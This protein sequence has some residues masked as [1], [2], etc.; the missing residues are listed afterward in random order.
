MY[1]HYCHDL[2]F[3]RGPVMFTL[4]LLLAL[5]APASWSGTDSSTDYRLGPGDQIK[6]SVL[7]EDNLS[8]E[9][10]LSEQGTISYP[11]LG[12][13]DVG[14]K[15]T[16]EVEAII[17]NGL[18]GKYLIDPKVS[19][20][21]VEFRKFFVGGA[22]RGPG[23]FPFAPGMTMQ[24]AIAIAGGLTDEASDEILVTH[25]GDS[26]NTPQR[27]DLQ[28]K[29]RPGDHVE[30]KEAGEIVVE[31][32][33]NKAGVYPYTRGLTVHKALAL[34]GGPNERASSTILVI[35]EDDPEHKPEEVGPFTPVR[36]GDVIHVEE[37]FF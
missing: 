5:L 18:N 14:G 28:T 33:V 9:V 23:G 12:Q 10:R 36:P 20:N 21:I 31:G 32:S 4:G 25:E 37:S 2:Q 16:R 1:P 22:V 35:H 26:A 29:V 6:I 11:M 19:V 24:Q 13:I 34:A 8:M 17:T 7:H 15:T 27:V 3:R 30:V